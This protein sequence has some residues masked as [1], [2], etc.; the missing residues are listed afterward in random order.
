MRIPKVSLIIL[1]WNG[2]DV[3]QEC[4]RSAGGLD[5]PN[6]D[7][8]VVDNGST[9]GSQGFIQQNFPKVYLIENGQNLGF[10]EGQNIGIRYAMGEGADYLFVLNND[11]TFDRSVLKELIAAFED[12]ESIGIAGPRLDDAEN[13]TVVQKTGA[14]IAWSSGRTPCVGVK[15]SERALAKTIE[16]DSVGMFL[17]K[18]ALFEHIGFF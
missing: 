2:K 8:I 4:L 1:N 5:Y 14:I 11:I 16:V 15:G 18:P 9:D 6:Y 12:D 17:A 3:L 7:I 10:A 13:P